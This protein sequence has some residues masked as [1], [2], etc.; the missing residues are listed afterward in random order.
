MHM[1]RALIALSAIQA[2]G[3][4]NLVIMGVSM[5]S[6]KDYDIASQLFL[7]GATAFIALFG[8]SIY[9]SCSENIFGGLSRVK[10]RKYF[11]PYILGTIIF[12]GT[13]LI[14]AA[15]HGVVALR[16]T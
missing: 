9:Y 15:M 1:N 4:I 8:A 13:L 3:Y 7:F 10:A 2:T 12:L 11:R 6:L 5:L 16:K 14:I